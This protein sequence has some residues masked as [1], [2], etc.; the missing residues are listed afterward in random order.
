VAGQGDLDLDLRQ[1]PVVVGGEVP[2]DRRQQVAVDVDDLRAVGLAAAG[3]PP[4]AARARGV[5]VQPE[6]ALDELGRALG[7]PGSP[8]G[9]ARPGRAGKAWPPGKIAGLSLTRRPAARPLQQPG[10]AA[11]FKA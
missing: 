6:V 5:A 4:D 1:P 3:D 8:P 10:P 11:P 9:T 2:R 7:C